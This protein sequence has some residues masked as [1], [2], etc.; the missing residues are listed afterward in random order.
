M[1]LEPTVRPEIDF[2]SLEG[3]NATVRWLLP[4]SPGMASA[5]LVQLYG[6]SEDKI[7]EET[8]LLNVL[9]TKFYNLEYHRD[10]HVVVRLVNCGSLGPASKPYHIRINS[11]GNIP[12]CSQ[13][14]S[15]SS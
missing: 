4:G 11:Q 1:L 13:P 9:S 10:Y 15:I 7:L 5:F 8:S 3:R 2:S 6:P 14:I 12:I